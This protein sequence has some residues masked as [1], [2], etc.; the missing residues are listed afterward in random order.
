M[1]TADQASPNRWTPPMGAAAQGGFRGTLKPHQTQGVKWLLDHPHAVLADDVGLGKTIQALALIAELDAAGQLARRTPKS[2]CRILWLTDA[3]L[4]EQTKREV[5]TFLPAHT[6][7]TGL[8]PEFGASMKWRKVYQER[9]GVGPDVL[10][11]SY[12]MARARAPWL[13]H[14]TPALVVLDEAMK[15]KSGNKVF[16]AVLDVTTRSDRV[17][18]MTA[19]PLENNPMEL[20]H[21]LKVTR[22]PG[23][24]P[25]GVFKS[26]FVTWK[27]VLG[28]TGRE[29]RVPVGWQS[30]R[31]PEVQGY[32]R[33]VL[34]QRN[35]ADA[36]LTLPER[37]GEDFRL[38][39]ISLAQQKAYEAA[40][41]RYG[42]G[43]VVGMEQAA[44]AV[45]PES[46]LVDELLVEL[47]A[48]GDEQAVVFCEYL[49]V[50]DLVESRLTE[51]G[52]SL[53][54]IEGKI[55]EAD[56]TAAVERFRQGEV[57]V[58]LGS[59]VLERGLNL[60]HCRTLISLDASWNP[61]RE[62]QRE[63]RIRRIG[64]RHETFR[65]LTLLPDTPLTR[66]KVATL[67]SKAATSAAVATS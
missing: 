47:A 15:V 23:L 46:R 5:E 14:S 29:E 45:G 58:L 37:T 21:L 12:D 61:A 66:S 48:M 63:G 20:F 16:K 54:R 3:T 25:E 9:F 67:R 38:V 24:W 8:D 41:R 26:D 35:A 65:H 44:K 49:D 62:R 60:Q 36:G 42:R 34:L 33:D 2:V 28:P 32:L 13:S 4:L 17:V 40:S 43:A 19:T 7:L 18:S 30:H 31:L 59:R 53:A 51:R 10:V 1:S 64:S 55:K 57:R 52:T 56:R 11:L 6:V 22:A 39:P 27:T 50:L